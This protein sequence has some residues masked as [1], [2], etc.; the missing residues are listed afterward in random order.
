MFE[1]IQADLSNPTYAKA[2]VNL[3]NIY[4]L[5]PM[6]GGKEL[7][8]YVKEN[9]VLALS[10]RTDVYIIMAL[11]NGDPVGLLICFDG[12][13]TF[14][15]KPLLN[16][17][18]VVVKP[19]YRGQGISKMML[20]KAEQIA[21]EKGCCKLTLEVLEGN[22]AA[23]ASYSSCGFEGY[24]LDPKMGKALFWQKKL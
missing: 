15:C 3:L 12:F 11:I 7:P 6:G 10:S 5:D 19:E 24:D 20:K 21:I 14:S 9:I 1:I 8:D 2:L 22:K 18:D 23:K 16:V 4:A 13:S 17:H